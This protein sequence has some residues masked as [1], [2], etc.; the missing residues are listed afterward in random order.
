MI[1]DCGQVGSIYTNTIVSVAAGDLSTISLNLP[2]GATFHDTDRDQIEAFTKPVKVADLDCPSWGIKNSPGPDR[3]VGPPFNPIILPPTQL[4]T[5]DPAWLGCTSYP[6]IAWVGSYGVCKSLRNE[7]FDP[8]RRLTPAAALAPPTTMAVAATPTAQLPYPNNKNAATPAKTGDPAL[9][10]STERPDPKL[11]PYSEPKETESE[12]EPG[13]GQD[14]SGQ[15]PQAKPEQA[16]SNQQHSGSKL[17]P[18]GGVDTAPNSNEANPVSEPIP[19]LNLGEIIYNAFGRNNNND[20]KPIKPSPPPP[21]IITTSFF[22]TLPFPLATSFPRTIVIPTPGGSAGGGDQTATVLNPSSLAL[23]GT[24]I[25]IGG[26][27]LTIL[28]PSSTAT[29]SAAEE[30]ENAKV[31]ILSLAPENKLL[32]GTIFLASQQPQPLPT[33]RPAPPP[34]PME[35]VLFR[36]GEYLVTI[37]K[38]TDIRGGGSEGYIIIKDQTLTPGG[39]GGFVSTAAAVD[40]NNND[41]IRVDMSFNDNNNNNNNIR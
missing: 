5:L 28:S 32:V 24:T 23:S 33:P 35:E 16:S 6:S 29:A 1:N 41:P 26:G 12:A 27:P 22:Q 19:T 7:N 31:I 37:V 36:A 4:I 34:P 2:P 15:D 39:T 21:P 11:P 8:P 3:T 17:S 25:S 20:N 10:A 38:N 40:N 13:T 18:P 9:P 30:G 14:P